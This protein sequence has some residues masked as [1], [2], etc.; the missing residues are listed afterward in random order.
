[1]FRSSARLEPNRSAASIADWVSYVAWWAHAAPEA[2]SRG[3]QWLPANVTEIRSQTLC[4]DVEPSFT[5]E[6]NGIEM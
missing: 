1:M 2:W 6:Q 4:H 5:A 3:P